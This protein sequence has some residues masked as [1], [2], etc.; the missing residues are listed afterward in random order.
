MKNKIKLYTF[1]LSLVLFFV[2]SFTCMAAYSEAN[3]E[4]SELDAS[5]TEQ[6]DN[7]YNKL[8]DGK[9][10]ADMSNI[11]EDVTP[12]DSFNLEDY[13]DYT[14]IHFWVLLISVVL[15]FLILINLFKRL[16]EMKE[17]MDSYRRKSFQNVNNNV[18]EEEK[19]E[20]IDDEDNENIV[21]D[22]EILDDDINDINR[23]NVGYK[24]PVIGDD[25][26]DLVD[27]EE[28]NDDDEILYN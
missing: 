25:N 1:P 24:I 9:L 2:M 4:A 3:L 12:E 5:T 28:E 22:E 6:I 17:Q 20:I 8:E 19:D 10:G 21:E 15:I 27:G 18:Y 16:G 7:F 14:K 13:F 26:D 11:S 23:E